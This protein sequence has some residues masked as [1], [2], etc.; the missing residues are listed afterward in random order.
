MQEDPL[1][2][3]IGP[4]IQHIQSAVAE[5]AARVK[6]KPDDVVLMAVTKTYPVHYMEEALKSGIRHFGENKVQDAKEKYHIF[7]PLLPDVTRHMIGHLQTNK[8][9][10]AVELFDLIHSVDSLRLAAEIDKRAYTKDKNMDILIEVNTSREPSKYGVSAEDTLELVKRIAELKNI[11]V[12]GLMTIGALSASV[13]GDPEKVR[14]YFRKL[15]ELSQFI[16]AQKI[17]GVS[18]DYLSM[19]MSLDYIPAIEEGANLIRI[20]TA[21]FGKRKRMTR[22]AGTTQPPNSEE[23]V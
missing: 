10:Q 18:M 1:L 7:D 16:G 21:I 15:S 14:P 11:R 22:N 20:G 8:V 2:L 9:R 19:G 23:D 6:R 3:S 13:A 5:T 4:N 17:P 12:R